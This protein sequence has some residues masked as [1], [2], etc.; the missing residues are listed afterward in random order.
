MK[1]AIR[2]IFLVLTLISFSIV[3][4]MDVSY[5]D[6]NF[7]LL[8]GCDRAVVDIMNNS[9]YAARILLRQSSR[10]GLHEQALGIYLEPGHRKFVWQIG[11]TSDEKFEV[12]IDGVLINE[13]IYL[14]EVLGI[15]DSGV[16]HLNFRAYLEIVD[17][18][19]GTTPIRLEFR[20]M[21][22]AEQEIIADGIAVQEKKQRRANLRKKIRQLRRAR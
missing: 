5:R 10:L 1:I 16:L 15:V 4:G 18:T 12:I 14:P 17:N 13:Q 21:T 2:Q 9:S 6:S 19:D 20:D 8:D 3:H 11:L 22:I 7:V